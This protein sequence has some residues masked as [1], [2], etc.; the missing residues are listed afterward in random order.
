MSWGERSCKN[1][2]CPIPDECSLATCN[3][4]CRMYEW[5]GKTKPDSVPTKRQ[6]DRINRFL[7]DNQIPDNSIAVTKK[8]ADR[9]VKPKPIS[10]DKRAKG[11]ASRKK[12][13]KHRKR[14][15]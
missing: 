9:A 12:A 3:V 8:R 11:K 7:Q 6:P 2:P 1:K 15:R 5:D 10:A 4:D 13:K 14:A